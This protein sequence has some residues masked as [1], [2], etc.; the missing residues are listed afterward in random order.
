MDLINKWLSEANPDFDQG[1][2]LLCKFS[3]NLSLQSYIGRK[4]NF[5]M[6]KYELSKLSK[7]PKLTPNPHYKSNNILFN[8][9]EDVK[10][11]VEA[12][13]AR[14]EIIEQS[15][16]KREDLPEQM[17]KLFDLN[18]SD[19][20]EMRILHEKLKNANSESG[21]KEF[22][23]KLEKLDKEI[24]KRWAII[25]SGVI[26]EVSESTSSQ[27]NS[28]RAYISKMIKKG[29]LTPQQRDLVKQK[30]SELLAVNASLKPET[31]KKL[32]EL[33]F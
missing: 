27:I 33:G 24:K 11:Q 4:R 32:K 19:Y 29:N 12:K 1:F 6:L 18:K 28:A 17:Q 25:D 3:R 8:K 26:P 21:R 14:K 9:S 20:Q 31:V 15:R 2:A 23:D 7:M 13:P 30:Y 16:V 22:R 5:E 10:E